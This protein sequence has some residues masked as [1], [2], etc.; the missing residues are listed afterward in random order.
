MF[1]CVAGKMILEREREERM[2]FYRDYTDC[3]KLQD[4]LSLEGGGGGLEGFYKVHTLLFYK[5]LF[6]IRQLLRKSHNIGK[7]SIKLEN[8]QKYWRK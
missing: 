6:D 4:H 5:P 8:L 1:L 7:S 3:I 2:Q